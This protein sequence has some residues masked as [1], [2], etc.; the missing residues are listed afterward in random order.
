MIK[1]NPNGLDLRA[2]DGNLSLAMDHGTLLSVEPGPGRLLGLF[3]LYVLPRRL[4]LDFRDVVD[5]GMAFDKVRADFDIHNGNAFSKNARIKTPSSNITINGRIGLAAR[6][7]DEHVTITP[8]VGS[9][10]AIAS[11]LFGG[12]FIGAAVFAVQELLKQPIKDFSS[13]GYTLKGSWDNPT[14]ADPVARH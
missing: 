8:K 11:A 6:D 13:V 5:K 14:I 9:G 4:R 10:L 12:P 2:L 7:Y 3:N 1:P